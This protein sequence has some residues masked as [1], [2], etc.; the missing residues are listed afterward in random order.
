M[1]VKLLDAVIVTGAGASREVRVP[2]R[3]FQ[4]YGTTSAGAGAAEVD[5]E[6]SN[7][8]TNF[9]VLGTITLVLATTASSDG[10]AIDAPWQYV[11]GNVKSISGT[12]ATVTLTMGV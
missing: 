6:V 1:G 10:F 12:N 11:R 4:L 5:I 3:T 8:N 2:K 9:I 7:D